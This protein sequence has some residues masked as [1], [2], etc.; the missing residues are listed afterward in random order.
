MKLEGETAGFFWL[1]SQKWKSRWS[2]WWLSHASQSPTLLVR[3]TV[4]SR[5]W[6][7]A[8]FT[9]RSKTRKGRIQSHHNRKKHLQA[10]YC[11]PWQS[12]APKQELD[13]P[14]QDHEETRG[15]K[16][17]CVRKKYVWKCVTLCEKLWKK[18]KRNRKSPRSPDTKGQCV[19]PQTVHHIG[20][21]GA[22][23]NSSKPRLCTSAT[24]AWSPRQTHHWASSCVLPPFRT[25]QSLNSLLMLEE[26]PVCQLC[27]CRDETDMRFRQAQIQLKPEFYCVFLLQLI[28]RHM[29]FFSQRLKL[30]LT[31]F[32]GFE[33]VAI[34]SIISIW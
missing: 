8:F 25:V 12:L 26:D 11:L 28:K 14:H 9:E 5:G 10:C 23:Q 17:S 27:Q 4:P 3:P 15:K 34:T 7:F 2:L 29:A 21:S 1:D 32:S 24:Q 30:N 33:S 13:L 16:D 31:N 18:K 19:Q 22:I 6:L 20:L